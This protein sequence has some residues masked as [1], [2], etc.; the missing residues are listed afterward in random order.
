MRHYGYDS[1]TAFSTLRQTSPNGI[2]KLRDIAAN[3]SLPM[4]KVSSARRLTNSAWPPELA[5]I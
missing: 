2:I 3:W 1:D 4:N 5:S